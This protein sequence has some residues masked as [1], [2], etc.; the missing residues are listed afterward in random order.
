MEMHL[1]ELDQMDSI[2]RDVPEV[3][4]EVVVEVQEERV[5]ML[6]HQL[7][8]AE[9]GTSIPNIRRKELT[10]ADPQPIRKMD[11]GRQE[12]KM[13]KELSKKRTWKRVDCEGK[14]VEEALNCCDQ[15]QN[16]R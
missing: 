1:E 9:E 7:E 13:R 8:V 15:K 2:Q 16:H 5:K 4:L 10:E 14:S 12:M 11:F 3:Q 6:T